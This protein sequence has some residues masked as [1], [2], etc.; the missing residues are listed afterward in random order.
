MTRADNKKWDAHYAEKQG[1]DGTPLPFLAEN[2]D[3]FGSGKAL[4][5]AAGAGRNAIYLAEQGFQVSALDV[6][7][8]GLDL[9]RRLASEKGLSLQTI[10]ADLEN[11]NLGASK[12][13]LITKIYY[14]QPSL[15][16]RIREALKTGGRFLFHTFSKRHA[17]VGTFGPRNPAFLAS[18]DD[19]LPTFQ[20]DR[21]LISED[22][23]LTGEEG[24]QAVVRLLLE[25]L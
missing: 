6:S 1:T 24:T 12:F 2:I 3:K 23:I 9:C 4:V 22:T 15:F 19:T 13:D 8:V 17:E 16:P 18:L 11:F 14:H 5:L 20:A 21:I 25:K 7:Q 10:H